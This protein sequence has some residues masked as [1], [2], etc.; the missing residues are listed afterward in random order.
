M[1]CAFR[2]D[3]LTYHAC[4]HQD[5]PGWINLTRRFAT[6]HKDVMLVGD[7]LYTTNTELIKQGVE[8]VRGL[9]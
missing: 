8:H 1:S 3:F 7:D 5:Y 4:Y 2:N 9:A 6:E